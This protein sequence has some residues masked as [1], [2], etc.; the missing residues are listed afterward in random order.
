M[1][2]TKPDESNPWEEFNQE[3]HTELDKSQRALNEINMML[4]Q[5]QV[6][7]NKISMRSSKIT[8]DLQQIQNQMESLPRSDIRMAY[9]SALDVQQRLFVMRSQM[10]RLN[11]D[12]ASL[13]KYIKFLERTL[14]LTEGSKPNA[15][16]AGK[17]GAA[18]GGTASVEMLINAQETERQRLSRQMHDG[19][20]Q[21]LSNFILQ[22]EI[23]MRLFDVDQ[24]KAKGELTTLKAAAMETFQKVRNFIFELRP[25][26][27]DDLGL[28]PT[29]KRY[30]ENIKEQSGADVSIN[31]AGGDRRLEPY[32]EIMIFRFIQEILGI[33]IRTS[34]ATQVKLLIAL[35]ENAIRVNIDDNGKGFDLTTPE[36]SNE[37]GLKLMEERVAMVGGQFSLESNVGQGSKVSFQVP[38][39][40]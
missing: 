32:Q 19:P 27:L 30:V 26:M 15:K 6:E 29:I 11:S 8:N 36:G 21:A 40:S 16:P 18:A 34:Q 38:T 5:S 12:Q 37:P 25:M 13:D 3:V 10:D 24:V 35:D 14:E 22:T 20:A 23:A 28:T 1:A 31:V 33:A 39:K 7:L 2:P 4:E 17:G 9:D